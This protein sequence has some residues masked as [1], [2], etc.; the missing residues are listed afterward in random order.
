MKG[1]LSFVYVALC[2]H[3]A[4]AVVAIGGSTSDWTAVEFSGGVESD[5]LDD[6][7][8]GQPEGDIIGSGANYLEQPG[9]YKQYFDSGLA[10]NGGLEGDYLAFRLRV[11][12][13]TNSAGW[14]TTGLFGLDLGADGE[15]DIFVGA[16][17][18]A[19]NQL[20][21]KFYDPGTGANTSPNTTSV[22]DEAAYAVEGGIDAFGNTFAS[23]FD[24]SPVTSAND[25]FLT[26][27]EVSDD[28]DNNG[29][30]DY[31]MSLQVNMVALAAAVF[32]LEGE[33]LGVDTVIGILALTSNQDNAFNQDLNGHNGRRTN[34]G[35]SGDFSNSTE[36]WEDLGGISDPYTASGTDPVPELSAYAL[37][38]GF[39]ALGVVVSHR[40]H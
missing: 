7:Q 40:R 13:D 25:G 28:L 1:L 8:T 19:G 4:Y 11:S 26:S 38:F 5:Y 37:I 30:D 6:Q 31:F 35:G 17:K 3:S 18:A 16:E 27:G 20:A 14:D 12:G 23:L 29:D 15:V 32:N 34:Q 21:I 22:I 2:A 10:G 33:I 36:T 9:L 39:I 24:F